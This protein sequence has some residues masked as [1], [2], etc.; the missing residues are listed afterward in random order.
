MKRKEQRQQKIMDILADS[1]KMRIKDLADQLDVSDETL[2]SD[3]VP[4]A[5]AGL[6]HREHGWV[7]LVSGISELPQSIRTRTRIREKRLAAARAMKLVQDGDIVFLDGATT[8]LEGIPA[9]AGKHDITVATT[10]LSGAL[11]LMAMNIRTI[12]IG[13]MVLNKG[14]RTYG[15]FAADQ[16]DKIQFDIAFLGT[17]G[18]LD[19]QG[20]TSITEDEVSIKRHLFQQARKTVVVADQEKFEMRGPYTYCRFPEV[21]CLVTNQI[22]DQQRKR[23]TGIKEILTA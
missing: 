8:V 7:R 23:L 15:S 18:C 5:K 3:L 13:G 20:F 9:L 16:I 21:D 6:V 1:Q 22:T 19:A 10:S 12:M 2:R 17:D 11:R 14:E 4:L